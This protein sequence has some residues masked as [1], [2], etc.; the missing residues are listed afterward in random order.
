MILETALI[1]VIPGKEA[2][3][4]AAVESK[5]M[6]ILERAEGFL[7]LDISQGVERPSTI[8]LALLWETLED[9]TEK[10]RGG[11]LFTD[12]RSVISPFFSQPPHVEHWE[13]RS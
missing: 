3:F 2:E 5:G 4:I 13:P 8:M 10:F 1:H 9:H 12:W 6:A 7:G 11:P